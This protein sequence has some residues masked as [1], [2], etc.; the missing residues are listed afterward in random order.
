MPELLN[1]EAKTDLELEAM[2][3]ISIQIAKRYVRKVI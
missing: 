1:I 2:C 3:D